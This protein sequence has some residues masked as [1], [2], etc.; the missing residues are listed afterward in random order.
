M[1]GESPLGLPGR[2]RGVEDCSQ[3]IA[4]QFGQRRAV[5]HR[6]GRRD[7]TASQSHRGIAGPDLYRRARH[8]QPYA[9]GAMPLERRAMLAGR[10][11]QRL[12]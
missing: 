2:A 12:W 1:V 11:R 4:G 7:G 6:Q 8:G 9:V 5:P 10:L 3:I